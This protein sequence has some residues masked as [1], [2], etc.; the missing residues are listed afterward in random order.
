[1]SSIFFEFRKDHFIRSELI[2]VYK[3]IKEKIKDLII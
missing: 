2:E 1:M 3:Q